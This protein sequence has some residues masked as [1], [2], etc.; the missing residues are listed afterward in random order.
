MK[1]NMWNEMTKMKQG[2]QFHSCATLDSNIEPKIV[3][4]GG[5]NFEILDT[6][7]ILDFKSQ[8]WEQGPKLDVPIYMSALIADKL[9]KV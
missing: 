9:G 4:V 6:V 7:E 2:R 8:V 3:V 5:R 1:Q